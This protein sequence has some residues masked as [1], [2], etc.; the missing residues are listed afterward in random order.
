MKRIVLAL[1]LGLCVCLLSSCNVRRIED[2][3][4]DLNELCHLTDEDILGGSENYSAFLSAWSRHKN[5]ADYATRSLS[6]IYDLY[7]FTLDA[8]CKLTFR[9]DGVLEEGNLRVVLLSDGSYVTD[10]P[11]G[12]EQE[13]TLQ[14]NKGEYLV[15]F[16]AE[17][18]KFE[19]SLTVDRE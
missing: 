19:F 6:G 9:C 11:I 14:A 16:A 10:L 12:T 18:A 2:T 4:G 8:P 15:R 13:L 7:Y 5:G 1:I 3:N 17:S